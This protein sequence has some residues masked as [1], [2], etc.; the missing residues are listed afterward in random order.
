MTHPPVPESATRPGSDHKDHFQRLCPPASGPTPAARLPASPTPPGV[1]MAEVPEEGSHSSTLLPTHGLNNL[2]LHRRWDGEGRKS[3]TNR[4]AIKP[5]QMFPFV[6]WLVGKGPTQLLSLFIW[7]GC[8]S[9]PDLLSFWL[10]AGRG[11]HVL[12]AGLQ[13]WESPPPSGAILTR[14]ERQEIACTS[15]FTDDKRPPFSISETSAVCLWGPAGP[16]RPAKG[17]RA[18]V[19]RRAA[20]RTGSS[21]GAPPKDKRGICSWE[22]QGLVR[23]WQCRLWSL[24]VS[25]KKQQG[26]PR[27]GREREATEQALC[28][29]TQPTSLFFK[30]SW[31]RMSHLNI[32]GNQIE[33]EGKNDFG[34]SFSLKCLHSNLCL[35]KKRRCLNL[36]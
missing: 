13:F 21:K 34:Q 11:T 24:S 27:Q 19:H 35:E 32:A 18:G 10:Q 23:P 31:K 28:A 3:M 8:W 25:Y 29:I 17:F 30:I 2:A 14:G 7:T 1:S 5:R 9:D 33:V 16:W 15:P 6:Y 20:V 36:D 22:Q 12:L 4:T 26:A